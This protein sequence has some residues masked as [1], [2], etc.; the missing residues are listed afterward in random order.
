M[1]LLL[2]GKLTLSNLELSKIIDENLERNYN[3]IRKKMCFSGD[4]TYIPMHGLSFKLFY[5]L[6]ESQKA[7]ECNIDCAEMIY[8]LFGNQLSTCKPLVNLKEP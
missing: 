2:L 6:G 5:R 4:Y 1:L 8:H 3:Q 7:T